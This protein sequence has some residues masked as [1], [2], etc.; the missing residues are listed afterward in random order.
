MKQS[1]HFHDPLAQLLDFVG[2]VSG[3]SLHLRFVVGFRFIQMSADFF[4]LRYVVRFGVGQMGGEFLNLGLVL[5]FRVR[6][7]G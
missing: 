1:V 6:R 2:V 5:R 3:E 4:D 7:G